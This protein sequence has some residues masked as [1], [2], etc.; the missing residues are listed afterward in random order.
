MARRR[1]VHLDDLRQRQAQLQLGHVRP[2]N[3]PADLPRRALHR[4]FWWPERVAARIAIA[5]RPMETDR[6]NLWRL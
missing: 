3:T 4:E 6:A 5:E 2:Q 1:F